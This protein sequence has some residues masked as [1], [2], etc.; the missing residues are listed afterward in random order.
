MNHTIRPAE[1]CTADRARRL[2]PEKA[3]QR[4]SIM[5]TETDARGQH[6]AV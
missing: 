4:A 6:G 3:K 1:P 2:K 5:T